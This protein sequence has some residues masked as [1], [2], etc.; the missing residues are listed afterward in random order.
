MKKNKI[1]FCIVV[2]VIFSFLASGVYAK[3]E[4]KINLNKATVEELSK[5]PGLNSDL[6]KKIVATREENGE[7]VDMDELLD[8]EGIDVKLLRQ[9]KKYLIIKSLDGCN[10]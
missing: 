9:L 2:L 1:M 4:D 6:A 8:I 7:F 10:C 3:D 5:V